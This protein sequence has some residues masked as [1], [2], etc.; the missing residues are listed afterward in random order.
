MTCLINILWVLAAG[1]GEGETTLKLVSRTLFKS[2][3]AEP[4]KIRSLLYN[5]CTHMD[6]FFV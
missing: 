2:S 3:R 6:L 1:K 4:Q 5:L